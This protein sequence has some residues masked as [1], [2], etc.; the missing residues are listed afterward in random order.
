VGAYKALYQEHL[1][2]DFIH[3]DEIVAGKL[4]R[5]KL[6]YLPFAFMLPKAAGGQI[7]RFVEQ[8]G[9]VLAEARTAWNDEQGYC[10][11]SLPGFG[12]EKVFGCREQGTESTDR[13]TPIPIRVVRW[14]PSLPR[15]SPGDV[16]YGAC[17]KESLEPLSPQA[18]VVGIFEDGSPAIVVHPYGKGWAIFVGSLLS[19]AYYQFDQANS[20]K[21]LR[22]LPGLVGIEPGVKINGI[23]TGVDL[24]PHILEGTDPT[25][26][27][28]YL[29]FAFNHTDQ[30]LSPR[31]EIALRPGNYQCTDLQTGIDVP[32]T[33]LDGRL[34]LATSLPAR[35]IWL[36][37]VWNGTSN[38]Y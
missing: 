7:A 21:L 34:E 15:L 13:N 10:D 26:K 29:F 4:E 2:A 38:L 36:V 32:S 3:P 25:G 22:G 20:G 35:G 8:G 12:L 16:L 11:T 5:Y 17:F 28:Y 19:L 37:K 27:P 1:E 6:L 14:H 33:C 18:Q 9:V 30:E 23:E 31:F 24:E